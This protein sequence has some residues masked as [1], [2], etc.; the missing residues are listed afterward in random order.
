MDGRRADIDVDYRS[1][2]FPLAL[3]NG[4]LTSANSD[5][6]AGSNYGRHTN[7]WAGFG[8]WWQSIFGVRM[9]APSDAAAKEIG[10]IPLTPRAGKKDIDVMVDDFLRAWLVDGDIPAAMGYVSERS[11][12]C[13]AQEGDDR[14]AFD[15]GLAPVQLMLNL[16]A[17][18]E[19]L[20]SRDSL[21]GLVTGVRLTR[22]GLKV[23]TQPHHQ[24]FVIYAVPDDVAAAFDCES[25]LTLG[26]PK[27]ERRAYG[28]YFGAVFFI[29]GQKDYSLALLWARENGYWKI[30]SW[31]AEPIDDDE[32]AQAT[33]DTPAMPTP[34]APSGA[35]TRADAALVDSAKGFLES[36]LVRKDYD[37]AFKYLSPASYACYN[38]GV[39]PRRRRRLRPLTPRH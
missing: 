1:P 4:H 7:R 13:L 35:S 39:A 24:Q 33:D 16:K 12:A 23:V 15:L 22:P 2:T 32:G 9:S 21:E 6:R 28:R 20:G 19:A 10:L 17:A 38:L 27:K 5:V 25:R 36:W 14:S 8:N 3:F 26:D 30:V 31:Q 34:A 37:A 11:Y 18:H 29:D